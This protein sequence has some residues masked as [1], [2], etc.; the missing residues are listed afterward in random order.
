[1]AQGV[2][3]DELKLFRLAIQRNCITGSEAF[4]REM[5]ALLGKRFMLRPRG[6][7]RRE[8]V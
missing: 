4:A 6:R 5:E 1:M 7:P 2:K 3:E 8:G